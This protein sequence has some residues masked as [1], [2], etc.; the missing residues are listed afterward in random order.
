M[1]TGSIFLA[2]EISWTDAW[3]V[4][5][6]FLRWW[7]FRFYILAVVSSAAVNTGVFVSFWIMVFFRRIP[8]SKIAASYSSSI[9]NILKTLYAVLLEEEMA[10]HSSIL[11]GEFHGQRSLAG[12]SPWGRKESGTTERPSVTCSCCSPQCVHQFTCPQ[13]GQ[14]GSLFSTF[15]LCRLWQWPFWPVWGDTSFLVLICSSLIISIL[16]HVFMCF[17][18]ICMFS[19]E[20]CLFR[21]CAYFLIGLCVVFFFF[22]YTSC[23]YVLEINL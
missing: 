21:S 2:W 3:H 7:A 11:A 20:K 18:D 1:G 10:T 16:E 19:L 12:Y 15:V 17:L 9:F 4:L 8:K 22:I 14:E 6:P 23:L 5:Y 13:T